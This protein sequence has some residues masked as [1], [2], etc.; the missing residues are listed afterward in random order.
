WSSRRAAVVFAAP[1]VVI[2]A[3]LFH[4][5][6]DP[7]AKYVAFTASPAFQKLIDLVRVA[8][9]VDRDGYGSLLGEIDCDPFDSSIH[10]NAPEITDDGIDQDCNGEDLSMR[11]LEPPS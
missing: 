6:G 5:G 2:T 1:L 10:P 11:D 7:D 9:D 8:N 3:T 4:F